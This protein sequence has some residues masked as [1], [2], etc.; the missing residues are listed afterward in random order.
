MMD[1]KRKKSTLNKKE[2]IKKKASSM[3]MKQAS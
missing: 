1:A 2:E 3:K